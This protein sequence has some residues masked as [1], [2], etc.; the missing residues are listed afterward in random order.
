MYTS[1][2]ELCISLHFERGSAKL[3]TVANN[4]LPFDTSGEG[5]RLCCPCNRFRLHGQS[6]CF[7]S[8]QTVRP[9][10]VSMVPYSMTFPSS[11]VS[12]QR[13]VRRERVE[14]CAHDACGFRL[15]VLMPL[16]T[17]HGHIRTGLTS[18]SVEASEGSS[19]LSFSC[20]VEGTRTRPP[21]P[22]QIRTVPK[23]KTALGRHSMGYHQGSTHDFGFPY[24]PSERNFRVLISDRST[25]QRFLFA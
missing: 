25:Y 15:P 10:N 5:S 2:Q 6:R 18:P 14:R 11:G 8:N 22:I 24:S 9:W 13:L 19:G 1:L 16:V 20:L 17:L 21:R 4:C 3:T 23:H 12:T 7:G